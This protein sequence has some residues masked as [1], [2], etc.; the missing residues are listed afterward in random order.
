MT[1]HTKSPCGAKKYVDGVLKV[2]MFTFK[3]IY[4]ITIF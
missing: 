1:V 3:Y 2:E 4:F